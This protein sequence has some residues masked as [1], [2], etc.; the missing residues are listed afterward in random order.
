MNTKQ[1]LYINT[2]FCSV[3]NIHHH[4]FDLHN[5]TQGSARF[6]KN[7]TNKKQNNNKNKKQTG[8]HIS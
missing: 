8:N 6:I 1:C 5:S 4:P 7:K 3:E 2:S